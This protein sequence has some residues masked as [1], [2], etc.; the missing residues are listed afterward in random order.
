MFNINVGHPGVHDPLGPDEHGYYIYDSSDLDYNL[1]PI[2]DWIEIDQDEG[3][4]G[5]LLNLSDGGD[6]NG[7][8]NSTI[9]LDLPFIL[10]QA[11]N[12]ARPSKS[13]KPGLSPVT[14]PSLPCLYK[15]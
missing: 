7:I 3:G 6:G 4:N 12:F 9:T 2:Y 5:D 15:A 13:A 1:A 10:F 11:S 8:S 14:S